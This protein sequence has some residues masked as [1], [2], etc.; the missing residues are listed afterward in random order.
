VLGAALG[1]VA[2]SGAECITKTYP[3]FWKEFQKIGGEINVDE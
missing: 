1:N 2:I 3:D